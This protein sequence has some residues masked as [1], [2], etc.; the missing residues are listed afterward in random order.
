MDHSKLITGY[1]GAADQIPIMNSK[2]QLF[3]STSHAPS[4]CLLR[5][6]GIA[7]ACCKHDRY[8]NC[9]DQKS[10]FSAVGLS[11]SPTHLTPA[12]QQEQ[13]MRL[14][15]FLPSFFS[16]ACP[17]RLTN[18][19]PT[20]TPDDSRDALFPFSLVLLVL[21]WGREARACMGFLRGYRVTLASGR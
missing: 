17:Q 2:H 10:C 11:L 6:H 16:P 15:R 7:H 9:Q 13:L 19:Y 12:C 18:Y 14:K 1:K 3:K 5:S 4:P 21:R 20:D 8:M